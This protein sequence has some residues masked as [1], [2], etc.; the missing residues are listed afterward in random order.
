MISPEAEIPAPAEARPQPDLRDH[1]LAAWRGFL[2]AHSDLVQELDAELTAEHSLSLSAYD[3][4]VQLAHSAQ[5]RLRMSELAGS[6]LLSP[7]GMTRLVDR[8]G[9]EGLVERLPCDDDARGY[10]AAITG[11]G[12]ERFEAA[13]RTHL[14]GVRRLFLRHF[15]D[16]ELQRLG[17]QWRRLTA[18]PE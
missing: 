15:S 4:L 8:L 13:R 6:V 14:D 18:E 3:V 16:A 1:E 9:D 17:E 2:R 11:A 5:G 12:R 10:F 7:S